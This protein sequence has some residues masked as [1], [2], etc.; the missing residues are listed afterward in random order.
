MVD[1]V[2]KA[3]GTGTILNKV[4]SSPKT[5]ALAWTYDGTKLAFP[6]SSWKAPYTAT[7]VTVNSSKNKIT[8]NFDDDGD[9]FTNVAFTKNS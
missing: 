9:T 6:S 7:K 1:L 3:D 8:I 5:Y 4:G 2:F